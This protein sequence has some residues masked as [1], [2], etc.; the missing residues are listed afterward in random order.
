MRSKTEAVLDWLKTGAGITSMEAFKELGV[1]RLSAVIFNLRKK[2]YDIESETVEVRD[3]F[4]EHCK[5]ARYR[6]RK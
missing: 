4:G 2:G 1:T 6:L 3:R 5:V